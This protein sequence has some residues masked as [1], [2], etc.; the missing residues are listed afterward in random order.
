M[1]YAPNTVHVRR[2]KFPDPQHPS[3]V[4][5]WEVG[6]PIYYLAHSENA[7]IVNTY[8]RTY[9]SLFCK[10]RQFERWGSE[11]GHQS[12]H[13]RDYPKLK[14]FI[15][16]IPFEIRALPHFSAIMCNRLPSMRLLYHVPP[17][18]DFKIRKHVCLL[19]HIG[20]QNPRHNLHFFIC[21]QARQITERYIKN[22]DEKTKSG[23][24]LPF[25]PNTFTNPYATLQS[26]LQTALYQHIPFTNSD[27]TT[28]LANTPKNCTRG[29]KKPETLFEDAVNLINGLNPKTNIFIFLDGSSFEA[30]PD[31]VHKK[32]GCS[33][34]VFFPGA[35]YSIETSVFLGDRDAC[36]AE[37]YSVYLALDIIHHK[38][39]ECQF[40]SHVQVHFF[41]DSKEVKRFMST[42]YPPTKHKKTGS[43]LAPTSRRNSKTFPSAF[44]LDSQ[45]HKPSPTRPRRR[46]S[47]IRGEICRD[48]TDL[49][50][51]VLQYPV[52][53]RPMPRHFSRL[54]IHK[55]L[56]HGRKD[57]P[58]KTC[59]E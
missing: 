24:I 30:T 15:F 38:M 31:H 56:E 18:S 36:Y 19:C 2:R 3:T 58:P 51:C 47:K 55:R 37:L 13:I 52:Q 57:P 17:F 6:A 59:R 50:S 12:K 48:S 54:D 26:F 4:I 22:F 53:D 14:D 9:L 44:P 11:T 7:E 16:K 41:T 49:P 43:V 25:T 5:Q 46:T 39:S 32:E 35:N 27:I 1:V 34:I 23:K 42:K 40:P 8:P 10:L 29:S 45:S 28:I 20:T 33:A 21:P